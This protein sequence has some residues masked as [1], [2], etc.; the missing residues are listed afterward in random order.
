MM[1]KVIIENDIRMILN[2]FQDRANGLGFKIVL[3][4]LANGKSK[5]NGKIN[6]VRKGKLVCSMCNKRWIMKYE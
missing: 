3:R 6:R 1:K 5:C 2:S 4:C